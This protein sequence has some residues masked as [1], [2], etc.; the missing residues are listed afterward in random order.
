MTTDDYAVRL[1]A[2]MAQY[3]IAELDIEEGELRLHLRLRTSDAQ[4]PSVPDGAVAKVVD[5][6]V[7]A[8]SFGTFRQSHPASTSPPPPLPRKVRAGDIVGYLAIA[9][10]LRPIV[11]DH[12]LVLVELQV[13]EGA[14][15]SYGDRV[16]KAVTA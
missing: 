2:M 1:E 9:P 12:D 5:A 15:V 4:R 10:L 14:A 6:Y 13:D 8:R 16:F 3:G 11:A 7:H